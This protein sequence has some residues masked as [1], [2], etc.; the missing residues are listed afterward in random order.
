MTRSIPSIPRRA[1]QTLWS[2]WQQAELGQEGGLV[3]VDVLALKLFAR[4]PQ[5]VCVVEDDGFAGGC[6]VATRRCEGPG[7]RAGEPDLGGDLVICLDA[8][9]DVMVQVGESA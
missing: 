5:Y 6:D 9:E 1:R 8:G 4:E 3:E 2:G 7:V